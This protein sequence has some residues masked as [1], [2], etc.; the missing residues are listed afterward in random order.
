MT[1]TPRRSWCGRAGLLAAGAAAAAL[2][3]LGIASP[4]HADP[5][6]T[7]DTSTTL[8]TG[9]GPAAAGTGP[10]ASSSV[11]AT[12]APVAATTAAAANR[13][14]SGYERVAVTVALPR[15]T[16][17]AYQGTIT[18]GTAHCPA[19]KM[20]LSGGVA[21]TAPYGHFAGATVLG[22][23]WPTSD[24]WAATVENLTVGDGTFTVYAICA[25]V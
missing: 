23:S 3:S 12:A 8:D 10:V 7:I 2:L 19:G 16:G 11:D 6:A 20:P 25:A 14:I 13:A 1:A 15:G 17:S 22:G 5:G 24:G 21:I 9:S 4:A 18:T